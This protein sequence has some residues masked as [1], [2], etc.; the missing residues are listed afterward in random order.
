M[1]VIN[2]LPPPARQ[3][4]LRSELD[5][6]LADARDRRGLSENTITSYRCDLLAAAAALRLPLHTISASDI[7]AFLVSRKEKPGTTNRRIAS[8]RRFFHWAMRQGY[9]DR[10]P[11]DLIEAK[12]EDAQLPRPI[13]SDAELKALD[14]AIACAPQPYRLIFSILRETGMRADEVLGLNVGDVIL[15]AGREGLRICE[16]KNNAERTVVLT[17]DIM[18]KTIRGLRAWLRA[19]GPSAAPYMP[20]FRSNRG[21]R[22]SYDALHYRWVQVCQAAGLVDQID[23]RDQPR[24]TIHQLRHTVGSTLITQYPE[25]IVSRMLGHRDPRSTRRYAEVT[26]LQVR[27]ALAERRR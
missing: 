11:V 17:P 25:Q 6:F 19:L 2:R 23:G 1:G 18:P 26:E 22:V 9:C 24:Y 16:A 8:L 7:E 27:A 3:H 12:R 20:L 10:N 14:A 5:G 4:T 13:R 21:T 15:E